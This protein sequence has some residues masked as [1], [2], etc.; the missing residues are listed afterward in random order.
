MTRSA[1][2][3]VGGQSEAPKTRTAP[4]RRARNRPA[5][6][7]SA[8]LLPGPAITLT[9]RPYVPPIIRRAARAVAQPARPTSTPTGSAAA[10]SIA[11]ISFGVTI[12]ITSLGHDDGDRDRT[13][14]AQREVPPDDPMIHGE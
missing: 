7:P 12:G 1:G 8:P 2:G 9:T 4:P 10:A 14:V 5:A 3:R 11:A 6:R 13:V